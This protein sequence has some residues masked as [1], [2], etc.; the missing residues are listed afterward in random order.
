MSD[1]F[2]LQVIKAL[3][4]GLAARIDGTGVYT[5]DLSEACVYGRAAYGTNDPLPL[6]SLIEDPREKEISL[7]TTV[8]GKG[9]RVEWKL[10]MQGF[11]ENDD[12]DPTGPAYVLGA[13]LMHGLAALALEEGAGA[14]VLSNTRKTN[15][16]EEIRIGAPI[17]RPP[18]EFSEK[19]YCWVPISLQL[20]ETPSQPFT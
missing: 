1:P 15:R 20:Y 7:D 16:V 12:A 18:D 14:G 13:D 4:D 8:P 2:R 19:A 5:N 6:A 3:R 17:T 10:L 11:V 9:H